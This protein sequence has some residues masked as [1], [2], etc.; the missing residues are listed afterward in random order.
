MVLQGKGVE[1]GEGGEWVVEMHLA[2]TNFFAGRKLE[3]K[4]V[5]SLLWVIKTTRF[6]KIKGCVL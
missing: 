3:A 2:L 6:V 4:M 5:R 1:E